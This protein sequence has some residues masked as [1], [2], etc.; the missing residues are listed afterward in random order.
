MTESSM[1]KVLHVQEAL[2]IEKVVNVPETE[3]NKLEQEECEQT[4]F[5]DT[6]TIISDC[7]QEY[8]QDRE[9]SL[10]D[11]STR[12]E[13]GELNVDDRIRLFSDE[14]EETS[15]NIIYRGHAL[16]C[17]CNECLREMYN[18]ETKGIS[19][20]HCVIVD[21]NG[22]VFGS[23]CNRYGQL[24][25]TN[26]IE[27]KPTFS[28]GVCKNIPYYL[29][30]F[31][32]IPLPKIVTAVATGRHNTLYLLQDR[33]VWGNG[34]NKY[35][36][37][38][39]PSS[40]TDVLEP[41]KLPIILPK[42]QKTPNNTEN[43]MI[44]DEGEG[45]EE[46]E[47]KFIQIAAGDNFSQLVDNKDRLWSTIP[48]RPRKCCQ[49]TWSH[50]L[51]SG[52]YYFNNSTNEQHDVQLCFSE[53]LR[54]RENPEW[55]LERENVKLLRVAFKVSIVIDYEDKVWMY[56]QDNTIG[57]LGRDISCPI[58]ENKNIIDVAIGNNFYVALDSD[59]KIWVWGALAMTFT[60]TNPK[61]ITMNAISHDIMTDSNMERVIS[62]KACS[63]FI[64]VTFEDFS[65]WEID[66]NCHYLEHN[67]KIL[68]MRSV[69]ELM[70]NHEHSNEYLRINLNYFLIRNV[71]YVGSAYHDKTNDSGCT[72]NYDYFS[73]DYDYSTVKEQENVRNIINEWTHSY[74]MVVEGTRKDLEIVTVGWLDSVVMV[75]SN[76]QLYALGNN[77]NNQLGISDPRTIFK[78]PV[79]IPDFL[80][81]IKSRVFPSGKSCEK[82][83][84]VSSSSST[85]PY[86]KEH[87]DNSETSEST[88]ITGKLSG[89]KRI[90][91]V[92]IKEPTLK[93]R[94]G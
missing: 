61:R 88:R 18:N 10:A 86:T 84:R 15:E 45:E 42:L 36:C 50:N 12:V 11:N 54:S 74:K 28:V 13:R 35:S 44:T 6:S 78:K 8:D 57:Y 53:Y 67:G 37:L 25:I 38:G 71:R 34:R 68:N 55:S 33:T 77:V 76:G 56:G 46:E 47:A 81:S 87:T 39:L 59:G 7:E 58:I 89:K 92:N 80:G 40:M 43:V 62:I 51:P 48:F 3:E 52:R 1:Q 24:G 22:I 70:Y 93:K 65:I 64:Y 19:Y 16:G 4:A 83:F 66:M 17:S 29:D 69:D 90:N 75:D 23:G 9:L 20:S 2:H 91:T 60:P 5:I 26:L 27:Y 14:A 32:R 21:D 94:Y 73:T 82:S 49:F 30:R 41:M 79:K 63:S 72:Q 31:T 85:L